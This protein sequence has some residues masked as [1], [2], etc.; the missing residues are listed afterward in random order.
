MTGLR[1]VS[2]NRK[3]ITMS[4]IGDVLEELYAVVKDR[5]LNPKEGAY[6]TYLFEKG[7]DKICKKIGEESTEVVIAAKNQKKS[8]VVYEISD[9][10]YHLNVLMLDQGVDWDDIYAELKRRRS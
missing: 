6:T 9:L 8:E 5:K 1:A 3:D 7:I 4:K 2:R 10:I